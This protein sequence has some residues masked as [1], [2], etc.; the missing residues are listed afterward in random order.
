MNS[1]NTYEQDKNKLV[2][3]LL[4]IGILLFC[5]G[6][7]F[8]YILSLDTKLFNFSFNGIIIAIVFAIVIMLTS[9]RFWENYYWVPLTLCFLA[10][11]YL[12]CATIAG[13]LGIHYKS[14]PLISVINGAYRWIRIPFTNSTIQISEFTRPALIIFLGFYFNNHPTK[15]DFLKGFGIPIA[16]TFVIVLLVIISRSNT[17]AIFLTA[18]F[19]LLFFKKGVHRKYWKFILISL[20]VLAT[21][22]SIFLSNKKTERLDNWLRATDTYQLQMAKKA[23]VQGSFFGDFYQNF[24]YI[25]LFFSDFVLATLV[26]KLGL[27]G[28]IFIGFLFIGLFLLS[29]KFAHEHES[30]TYRFIIYGLATNIFCSF[31]LALAVTTGIIPLTGFTTPFFSHGHSNLI[32]YVICFTFIIKFIKQD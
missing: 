32:S 4:F 7:T 23:I 25:P 24:N 21:I 6:Q 18:L 20:F 31:I 27:I 15:K 16:I 13:K 22:I 5:F 19:C 3:Y 11:L 12:A 29:L 9:K 30:N 10:L 1:Y 2:N 14:I 8:L 26:G 28:L 17:M